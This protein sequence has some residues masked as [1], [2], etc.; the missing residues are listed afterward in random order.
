VVRKRYTDVAYNHF[1][2]CTYR[3]LERCNLIWRH[4]HV[5]VIFGFIYQTPILNKQVQL[6][7]PAY[8][9]VMR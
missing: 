7:S 8:I 9:A 2:Y 1:M 6:V 3:N 5:L 4:F